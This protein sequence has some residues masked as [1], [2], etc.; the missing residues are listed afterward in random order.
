MTLSDS[1]SWSVLLG[2]FI[3]L[4]LTVF[5][6]RCCGFQF[7]G[8]MGFLCANI[9]VSCAFLLALFPS[10][11]MLSQYFL[12]A[13]SNERGRQGVGF[14]GRRGRDNLGGT[15]GGETLIRMYCMKQMFSI[16]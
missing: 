11:F 9:Y 14:G 7:C 13:C 12:D 8:F 15:W 4:N 2:L 6:R 16:K 1:L 3:Y 5:L 10:V